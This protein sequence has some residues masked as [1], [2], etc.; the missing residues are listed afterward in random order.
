M[1]CARGLCVEEHC[2]TLPAEVSRCTGSLSGSISHVFRLW[3][4]PKPTLTL[5]SRTP[6]AN[7]SSRSSFS[8][9]L[10]SLK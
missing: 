9:V 6:V 1:L 4:T 3:A 7:V 2:V 10:R 5:Q 8:G